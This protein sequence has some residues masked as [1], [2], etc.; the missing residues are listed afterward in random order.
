MNMTARLF[1]AALASNLLVSVAAASGFYAGG[2]VGGSSVP[3]FKD[4]AYRTMVNYG[5]P[6]TTVSQNNGS[7]QAAI[8]AGQWLTDN[9]GWEANL[10]GLGSSSGRIAATNATT[11]PIF[12]SY[13][14]SAGVVS[15]SLMGGINVTS[16]G[17][18]FLKAGAY[19]AG[20]TYDGPTSTITKNTA[21]PVLGGGFSW[22]VLKHMSVRIEAARYFR[23]RFPDFEFFTPANSYTRSN[24]N[25]LA[26]GAAYVF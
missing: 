25:T 7:G 3:D 22:L 12:T 19:D 9:F 18:I 10:V 13:Q 16:A 24:I 5:Y 1:A 6:T 14:Y 2:E 26:I 17:K 21:G 8:F 20:V 4:S 15:L 23:M 11:G